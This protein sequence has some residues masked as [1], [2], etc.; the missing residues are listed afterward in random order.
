M[1]IVRRGKDKGRQYRGKGE[2]RREGLSGQGR[3]SRPLGGIC[4]RGWLEEGG[5]RRKEEV[6]DRVYFGQRNEERKP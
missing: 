2:E 6:E 4:M 3:E 1:S 5:G